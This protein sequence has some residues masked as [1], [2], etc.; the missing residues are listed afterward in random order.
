[1]N[2]ESPCKTSNQYDMEILRVEDVAEFLHKSI[3]WV[4]RHHAKLGG[5]K[6]AGSI[7]FPSRKEIYEHIFQQNKKLVG[8]RFPSPK[9]EVQKGRI[10][11]KKGCGERGGGSK[12][13]SEKTASDTTGRANRHGLLGIGQ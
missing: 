8:I 9:E 4:S 11:K 3:A 7:L 6:I 2:I 13:G 5:V 1:M 10:Q 12:A